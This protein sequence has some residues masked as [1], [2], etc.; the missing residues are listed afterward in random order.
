VLLGWLL[1]KIQPVKK[2]ADLV[3]LQLPMIREAQIR[4]AVVLFFS[5]FR[6][7]YEAGGVGV[8]VMFDL[9]CQTVGNSAIRQD[10]LKA[11]QT[12]EQNG[13]FGD[14]FSKP[15]LLEDDLKGM[16]NTGSLSGQLDRSL[17]RIVET[18]TR[19]LDLTLQIF[20]QFFQRVVAFSVAMSIV[21]TVL[22][23]I[24]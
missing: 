3:L 4:Q 21:E 13:S 1:L 12:L 23:C 2:I 14:A 15:T 19:Q 7:V 11:R 6:M 9:A 10:L 22:I 5:T 17:T 24:R 20:N 8:P 16:I 18:A